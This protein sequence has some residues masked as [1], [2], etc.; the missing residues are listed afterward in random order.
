MLKGLTGNGST[1]NR[2]MRGEENGWPYIPEMITSL[3]WEGLYDPCDARG[4]WA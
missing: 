1:G 2:G 4:E 3:P